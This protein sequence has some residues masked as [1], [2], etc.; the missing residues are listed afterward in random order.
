MR[1]VVHDYKQI[2]GLDYAD[3]FTTVVKS[4]AWKT[5]FTVARKNRWRCHQS[6]VVTTFLYDFLDEEIY[7]QQPIS[8]EEKGS[9]ELVC[10]LKKALY[11]L[12][13]SPRVWFKTLRDFL[14]ELSFIQS[15]YD[16]SIFIA[17]D[18]SMIIAV[19]I[20]NI[21]IFGGNEK[22]MK[23][24]QDSLAKCFKM[25]D[26]GAVSHYLGMEV[27]VGEEKT[28]IRQS[29]YLSKVLKRFGCEDCKPCKIPMDPGAASHTELLTE[30]ADKETIVYY[31]SA[32]GSLMWAVTMTHPDLAYA[33]LILSR[34]LSN[35]GKEHLALLKNVFRYVS[36]TLD[37]GLTFM[38][39]DTSDVV[40][41]TDSDFAG[42]VDGCKSTGGFAFM[43][44]GGCISHQSKRQAVVALSLCESE[45][46]AMSEA[47][48]E[49]LWMRWFLEEVGYRKRHLPIILHADNQGAIALA[50]NPHNNRCLKHIHV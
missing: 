13:Q 28:T 43:L 36:G 15:E 48:K 38:S 46:M 14:K 20:N 39:E 6:D 41:F 23:G 24:V 47:G 5:L 10:L 50:K 27:D 2:E 8:L 34:Y 40:G 1:W 16:H 21:L 12:K 33:M 9:E 49:A 18:K 29:V 19:Y 42:V 11:R 35:P 4:Q 32:V 30:E 3:T 25:T 26:L 44:A 22:A 37:V 45:Y 31:Q 17:V 7:V